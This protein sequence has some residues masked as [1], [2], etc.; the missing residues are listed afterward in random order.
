M[1]ANRERLLALF[2][3]LFNIME[4]PQIEYV[5]KAYSIEVAG[6]NYRGQDGKILPEVLIT[7]A[8]VYEEEYPS[9]ID[10]P[11]DGTETIESKPKLFEEEPTDELQGLKPST[12]DVTHRNFIKSVREKLDE[13][14]SE[15][16]VVNDPN[17]NEYKLVRFLRDS[18]QKHWSVSLLQKELEFTNNEMK[19]ILDQFTGKLEGVPHVILDLENDTMRYHEYATGRTI[20]PV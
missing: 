19:A 1:S 9:D 15:I 7:L 14:R 18:D 11:D 8:D 4:D 2:D 10:I 5:L 13:K 16:D 12:I 17:T 20:F 6:G 3:F